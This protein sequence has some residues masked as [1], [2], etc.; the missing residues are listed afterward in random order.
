[1]TDLLFAGGMPYN[2]LINKSECISTF[3]RQVKSYASWVFIKS[4]IIYNDGR[5]EESR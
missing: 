3:R 4:F 5:K 1:M 2:E